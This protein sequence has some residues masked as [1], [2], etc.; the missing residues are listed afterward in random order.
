MRIL[1]AFLACFLGLTAFPLV[2]PAQGDA[3]DAAA[4]QSVIRGQLE[5]FQGD[6]SAKAWSYAAPN[7]QMIFPSPE[8]FMAMV[9][10]GYPPVYRPRS[11]KF[12]PLESKDGQIAQDVELVG[13]DGDY[14]HALY[15]I[16]RQPDGS[17]KITSCQ[18][19]KSEGSA[20]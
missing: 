13:P 6:D 4:I 8:S 12:G 17:W 19:I 9:R 18:L 15:T 10:K 20:A 14:W 3:P 7:I 1:V 16:A 11:W 2:A 5:A